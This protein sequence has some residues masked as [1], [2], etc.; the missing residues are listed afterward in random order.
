MDIEDIKLRYQERASILMEEGRK[1]RIAAFD[2]AFK[3]IKPYLQKLN[4]KDSELRLYLKKW[5]EE[6][7]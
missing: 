3:E 4:L 7:L 5:K 6:I 1:S 2:G